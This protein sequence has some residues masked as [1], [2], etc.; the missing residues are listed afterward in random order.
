VH[1]NFFIDE[2]VLRD[3]GVTDFSSYAPGG[4]TNPCKAISSSPMRS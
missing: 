1:G 2:E 3:E 4:E